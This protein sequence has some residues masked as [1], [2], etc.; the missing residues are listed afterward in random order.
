[1][2]FYFNETSWRAFLT[3]R[4]TIC[5]FAR[6]LVGVT[7]SIGLMWLVWEITRLQF[8]KNY[9]N[10]SLVALS[11]IGMCTLGIYLLHQWIL[12]RIVQYAPGLLSTRIG[13][14][15]VVVGLTVFCFAI[16]WLTQE[17]C[18]VTRKWIWGK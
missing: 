12:A 11:K 13:V 4:G 15:G 16:T 18:A 5:M 17:K 9:G 7:G 3:L 1:M 8:V 10:W 2:S 14:I 6:P